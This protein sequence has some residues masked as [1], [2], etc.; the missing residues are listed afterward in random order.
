MDVAGW[1]IW[2]VID[3]NGEIK[4]IVHKLEDIAPRSTLCGRSI[5]S[6]EMTSDAAG[7][8]CGPDKLF[9]PKKQFGIE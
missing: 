7:G 2:K 6:L 4:S 8:K 5:D 3:A 9:R 1:L